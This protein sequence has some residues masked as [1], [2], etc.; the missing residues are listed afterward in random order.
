MNRDF[1][2]MEH[3]LWRMVF[4]G[5]L[6]L[7]IFLAGCATTKQHSKNEVKE[8]QNRIVS[9]EQELS[10]KD[11][12][13]RFLSGELEIMGKKGSEKLSK[14]E[15]DSNEI[16]IQSKIGT[17]KHVQTA[18]KNAGFYKGRIDGR[19]GPSTRKAIKEFQKAN[20]LKCDGRVG[21]ETWSKLSAYLR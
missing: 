15:T 19:K 1:V 11:E 2:K 14:K 13:I 3:L 7:T 18:L 8:L 20:G 5:V 16:K 4:G 21:K 12:E 9:L 17:T 6:V 10:K